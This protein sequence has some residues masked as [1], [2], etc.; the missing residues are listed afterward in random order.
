MGWR[1]LGAAAIG[2]A[3][4]INPMSVAFATGGMETSL[5]VLFSLVTLG[6]AARGTYLP[7]AAA[8]AGI[9]TLV[10]PEGALLAAVVVGW[11]WLSLRSMKTVFVA[12]AAATP[13]AC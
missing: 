4:A 7:L 6:L 5:F 10:R 13:M 3:W 9:A 8:L 2:L 1:H 12:L 11:T